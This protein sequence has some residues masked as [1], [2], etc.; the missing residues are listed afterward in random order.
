LS[1]T[2]STRRFVPQAAGSLATAQTVAGRLSACCDLCS[3]AHRESVEEVGR[4]LVPGGL[5]LVCTEN[6]AS[7]HNLGALMLGYQPFSLTN[8]SRVRP[9]GNPFALHAGEE[10]TRDSRQH[11]HVLS[12]RA[13]RDLFVAHGF[14]V[15][16]ECGAGYHPF[17]GR[18]AS[19]LADHDP[20]HAHFIA[21]GARSPS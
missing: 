21:V 5:A 6:L 10:L 1:S 20:R 16:W 3:Y 9:I 8:V 18:A 15:E 7:W 19:W 17:F 4:V 11:V 2:S 14:A 12:F 13:L